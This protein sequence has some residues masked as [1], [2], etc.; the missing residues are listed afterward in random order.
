MENFYKQQLKENCITTGAL[1]VKKE[2]LENQ[3]FDKE[4]PKFQDWDLTLR[5]AQ[6]YLFVY[7]DEPL[8]TLYFKKDS[9]TATTSYEKAVAA[10]KLIEKK[11]INA[12]EYDKYIKAEFAWKIAKFSLGTNNIELQYFRQAIRGKYILR[13]FIIYILLVSGFRKKIKKILLERLR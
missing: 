13:R 6:N 12:K 7:C 8:I 10:L 1:L 2:C 4:L 11:H 3:Y 5:L 9:I